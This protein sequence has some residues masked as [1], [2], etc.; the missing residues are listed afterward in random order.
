M[1]VKE[2]KTT[3]AKPT[4][5]KAVA[6]I[7]VPPMK[8]AASKPAAK[9]PASKAAAKPAPVKKTA[10]KKIIF[11][12]AISV[13]Q[14][15]GIMEAFAKGGLSRTESLSGKITKAQ[16]EALAKEAKKL[17]VAPATLVAAVITAFLA[18]VK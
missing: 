13:E 8:K 3:A 17:G 11:I 7:T 14:I 10:V 12:E 6:S 2:V 9:K 1:A 18:G 5:R 16:K 15:K 4:A